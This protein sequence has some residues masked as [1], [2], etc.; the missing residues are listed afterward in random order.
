MKK[1]QQYK[2]LSFGVSVR[3]TNI[4]PL[5]VRTYIA[6]FIIYLL[7]LSVVTQLRAEQ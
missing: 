6:V 5:K 3:Y 2:V 4:S 1:Y 7:T